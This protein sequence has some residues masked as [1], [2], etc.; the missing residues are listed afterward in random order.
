LKQIWLWD[1][2]NIAYKKISEV[3]LMRCVKNPY[4]VFIELETLMNISPFLTV[5]NTCSQTLQWVHQQLLKAG[6]R[7][8]Q[9]FDLHTARESSHDCQCPHHGTDQCDCQMVVLLIYGSMEEPATLVLHGN[10]GK[11]LLSMTALAKPGD[12]VTDQIRQA[13]EIKESSSISEIG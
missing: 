12:G 7:S 13:L 10:D 1:I 9:T 6:L 2:G 4:N 3:A 5:S 11:T 8:V